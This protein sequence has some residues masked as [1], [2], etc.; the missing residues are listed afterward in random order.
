MNPI[1][2]NKLHYPVTVLGHGRRLGIWLQGCGIGC[3]GC[4]ARDTW[5]RTPEYALG[6]NTLV[7]RCRELAGDDLDGITISGGEPFEQPE[8]L[9]EL[10]T[11]LRDW[12]DDLPQPVDYLCYTGKPWRS[13]TRLHRDVIALLDAVIP[14]PFV[15]ALPTAPLRGSTNQRIHALTEL[16]E[17]RYG[18]DDA[19]L[20]RS[21]KQLQIGFD[22]ERMWLVG[23][24]ARG[25]LQRI[26]RHC[27]EQG[28]IFS[29]VSW[30]G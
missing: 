30:R 21:A 26:E 7:D 11:R 3:P 4:I 10:L 29:S 14:E 27:E 28:L 8:A 22:G 17:S 1:Y 13:V 9:R 16:G 2:V 18:D 12:T 25:D 24:P 6:V 23:I 15:A 19:L 20:E 5:E